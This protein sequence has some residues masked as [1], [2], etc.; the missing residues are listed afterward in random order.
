MT[1]DDAVAW[2]YGTQLHGIKLGLDN[3]RRLVETLGVR[4]GGEGA[5]RFIHVA[6]T[7]GKGS[8][9]AMLDAICRAGG[10]RTGLFTSPHLVT[11]RERI[12]LDG[13]M[14]GAD[15]VAA[16]LSRIRELVAPWEHSPT[17][18]E[19]TTALA[20]EWFQARGAEVVVLETGMGGRL[21]ATNVVE[22]AVCVLTSISLDHQQW[23]GSTLA[24]IAAEKAG[25]IKRGVPVVSAPQPPEVEAVI[26]EKVVSVGAQQVHFI[27][28]PWTES[29]VDLAGS[30]QL[31]NAQLAVTAIRFMGLPLPAPR[32]EE[33]LR[34][35][36]WPGRFQ[37][38]GDRFVLDGAH[39]PAA[40]RQLAIT[41][42]EVFG[43]EKAT[44][45]LGVLRD[46][47]LRGICRELLPIAARMIAVAVQ[48]ER[49]APA[50]EVAAIV[51]EL[52]PPAGCEVAGDLSAAI[53][54]ASESGSRV[55]ITGSLF[56]IG[57][58]I[59]HF[60]QRDAPL[61]RSAQ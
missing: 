15:E 49:S 43:E 59:A 32:V 3:I 50:Q 5:P 13:E 48:N 46:K 6:G 36:S 56:L 38:I 18:F 51:A 57:E 23:L 7:N 30:H 16:G 10:H 20:L 4:V 47:D 29:T 24:E 26:A 60:D 28:T 27:G 35:V 31:W 17:F 11:F 52:N 12:R 55:L 33:G 2:L 39:N 8:V 61:E 44:V 41:W 22:P 9:C 14:I 53:D 19:I 40:A 25:I 42:S 1:Y 58:A 34:T 54:A 21:D 45:I 37:R